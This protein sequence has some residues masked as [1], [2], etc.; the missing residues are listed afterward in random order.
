MSKIIPAIDIID[1]QC[2]RLEKGDYNKKKVYSSDPLDIAKGMEDAGLSYLHIVDLDGA[3]AKYPQN[4]DIVSSIV[5]NTGLHIDFGGGIKSLD[6]VKAVLDTGV[7][8]VTIGSLAV[9]KPDLVKEWLVTLGGEKIIIGVDV[10]DNTIATDGWLEKY[11]FDIIEFI[12][13][14]VSAGA[15]YFLCT[16]IKKDGMLSGPNYDLYNMIINECTG[17][18]LISSGGVKEISDVQKLNKMKLYGII[19]GKAIYEGKINIVE[20]STIMDA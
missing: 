14:Y 8:Q 7:K 4:L 13:D 20:L 9:K 15:S 12:K 6:A 5:N 1:G 2:V 3:K 18:N 10:W 19:I 17:I 16:D 11:D